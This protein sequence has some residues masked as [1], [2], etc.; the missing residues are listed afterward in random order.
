MLNDRTVC[1][2]VWAGPKAECEVL[3]QVSERG[4]FTPTPTTLQSRGELASL[5]HP[6]SPCS[7]DW[8]WPTSY[9]E[10]ARVSSNRRGDPPTKT[11]TS[12]ARN[13]LCP[14]SIWTSRINFILVRD[15]PPVHTHTVIPRFRLHLEKQRPEL[16]QSSRR[17]DLVGVVIR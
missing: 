2:V 13:E 15:R 8:G 14:C 3:S 17:R 1:V 6:H 7:V 4:H 10:C 16:N 11:T 5:I 12:W 9:C